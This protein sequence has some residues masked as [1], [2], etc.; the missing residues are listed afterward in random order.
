MHENAD[1]NFINSTEGKSFSKNVLRKL[2]N[3]V[4][5]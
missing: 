2:T 4:Y 5:A 3:Y 1:T